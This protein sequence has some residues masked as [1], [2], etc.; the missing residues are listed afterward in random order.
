MHAAVVTC[1]CRYRPLPEAVYGPRSLEHPLIMTRM[2]RT[3]AAAGE[4]LDSLPLVRGG[5]GML[6]GG[7]S[8]VHACCCAVSGTGA[9]GGAGATVA[10]WGRRTAAHACLPCVLPGLCLVLR[11]TLCTIFTY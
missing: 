6:G 7:C 3:D 11:D 5:V 1:Y 4:E 9:M 2:D 8:A 10:D